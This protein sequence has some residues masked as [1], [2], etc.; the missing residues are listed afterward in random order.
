MR[1]D[2]PAPSCERDEREARFCAL[3]EEMQACRRCAAAGFPVQGPPVFAGPLAARLMVI[4]QAP[5]AVDVQAGG[6]PW[7]GSGGGRLMGWFEVAGFDR[8]RLRRQA[9]FTALTRCFP[10]KHPD[11]RGDRAPT[12]EE[13]ALCEP[14]LIRELELVAP[15]VL[16]L[17]GRLAVTRFL[18]AGPLTQYVGQAYRAAEARRRALIPL[19]ADAWLIPLP[20][21][22]GASVWLNAP[23]HKELVEKAISHLADLRGQLNL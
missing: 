17:V 5:A 12:H 9:Y 6:V 14:F 22:S 21:P 3:R 10:G 13:Q 7:S 8:E 4:G 18:G 16:V 2:Q 1:A 11:G 23:D 20:H 19:P 15:V